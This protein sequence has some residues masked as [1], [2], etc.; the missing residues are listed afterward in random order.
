MLKHSRWCL[1]KRP[2]NLT[3]KQHRYAANIM[4]SGQ[5]LLAL[6][7]DI[8]DLSK[9]E[10]GKIELSPETFDLA[11]LIEDV[12]SMVQPLIARN[13]NV[14]SIN[15][16]DDLGSM[17]ADVMK[18]RQILFNLLSNAC[19]FTEHGTIT[20]DAIRERSGGVER[21]SLHVRDTGIGMTPEQMERL[22]QPFSQADVQIARKYGGTGLG[23]AITRQ[24]IE[25]H[26]GAIWAASDQG[27]GSTF[28][29]TLPTAS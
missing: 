5:R 22:F 25:Y 28:T 24:I 20:L 12:V 4:A 16:P 1:L 11:G 29:F 15:R 9:I 26:G 18:V 14:L 7:N 6:I 27:Y 2:E 13:A 3:E 19:K 21:L 10:A 8:L 23:L 17:Y